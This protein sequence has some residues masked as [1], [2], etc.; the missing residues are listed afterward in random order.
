M[1]EENQRIISLICKKHDVTSS[2]LMNYFGIEYRS[3]RYYYDNQY[4]SKF[5][6][7]LL[8]AD[9]GYVAR[10]SSNKTEKLET[11]EFLVWRVKLRV[12]IVFELILLIPWAIISLFSIMAFGSPGDKIF[13]YLVLIP[14]WLY[15]VLVFIL[16]IAAFDELY[17]HN[18]LRARKLSVL[19][20]LIAVVPGS[21]VLILA[22]LFENVML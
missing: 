11:E 10:S 7:V 21:L 13:A 1:D 14:F 22:M 16:G 3:G 19:P 6:R 4:Y 15:P 9:S 2:Q 5:T 17:A 18:Y 20:L 12:V 8:A